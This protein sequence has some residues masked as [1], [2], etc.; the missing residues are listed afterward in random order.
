MAQRRMLNKRIS[1]SEDANSL[2]LRAA[3]LFTWMIAHQDDLGLLHRS[4]RWVRGTVVPMRDDITVQDVEEDLLAMIDKGMVHLV[5]FAGKEY[6]RM[7]AFQNEQSPRRDR[8]PSTYLPVK[9]SDKPKE[10]WDA[11]DTCGRQLLTGSV[12]DGKP[13]VNQR[14]TN[15]LP[16][17]NQTD[18]SGEPEVN[19][20]YTNGNPSIGE[21]S[22]GQD[23]IVE[24]SI[25]EPSRGE[26]EGRT[27]DEPPTTPTAAPTGSTSEWPDGST[28]HAAVDTHPTEYYEA[29]DIIRVEDAS[30]PL[31]EVMRKLYRTVYKPDGKD[32]LISFMLSDILGKMRKEMDA[33]KLGEMSGEDRVRRFLEA[34]NLRVQAK[35]RV[36]LPA[37]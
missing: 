1:T 7:G 30:G 29:L 2:P 4:A 35:Y 33:G 26:S 28:G 19:Q 27:A 22:T 11:L 13:V 9:L 10:A 14:Y 6:I 37:A 17:V 8:S 32:K 5:T 23:S 3:L 34:Y 15:G 31:F 12:Q 36:P 25:D 18:T 21:V 16:T 20:R 24:A